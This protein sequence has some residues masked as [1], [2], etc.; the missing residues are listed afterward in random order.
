MVESGLEKQNRLADFLDKAVKVYSESGN[1]R[2]YFFCQPPTF[3]FVRRFVIG[4]R[5]S[6]H[7][8]QCLF[9]GFV[10]NR[11]VEKVKFGQ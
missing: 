11:F 7:L 5:I 10:E 2:D 6:Q 9:V 4:R 1:C 3:A 8:P